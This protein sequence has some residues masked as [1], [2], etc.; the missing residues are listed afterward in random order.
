[1]A[2]IFQYHD[3]TKKLNTI[4]TVDGEPVTGSLVASRGF[5]FKLRPIMDFIKDYAPFL[6]YNRDNLVALLKR[7]L[8]QQVYVVAKPSGGIDREQGISYSP[9]N[10]R[11]GLFKPPFSPVLDHFTMAKYLRLW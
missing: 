7:I 1:M 6:V 5:P 9:T 4:P 3:N 8:I 11:N 2:E 10:N